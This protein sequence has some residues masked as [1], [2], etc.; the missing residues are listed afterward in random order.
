MV[1]NFFLPYCC[2]F[3]YPKNISTPKSKKIIFMLPDLQSLKW[4]CH[5][6]SIEVDDESGKNYFILKLFATTLVLLLCFA[7]GIVAVWNVLKSDEPIIHCLNDTIGDGF[8]DDK[9][10][11][12]ECRYDGMDCCVSFSDRSMCEVCECHLWKGQEDT[13]TT[14][15]ETTTETTTVTTT[16]FTITTGSTITKGRRMCQFFLDGVRNRTDLNFPHFSVN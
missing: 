10:N 1:E 2:T 11:I 12:V 8:C 3:I 5:A 6:L 16:G 9:L 13:T 15:T 4:I 14:T 7:G